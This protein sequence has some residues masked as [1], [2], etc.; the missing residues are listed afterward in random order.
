L[1][2]KIDTLKYIDDRPVT[3]EEKRR[4]IAWG[5]G[6]KEAELEEKKKIEDE[7]REFHKEY[8]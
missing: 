4:T 1:I 3:D 8:V 7:K 2:L 6:G 5:V